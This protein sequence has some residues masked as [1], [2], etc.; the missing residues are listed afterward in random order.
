[1]SDSN[2]YELYIYISIIMF[3][4]FSLLTSMF[5]AFDLF[6]L[7]KDV[8]I[9]EQSIGKSLHADKREGITCKSLDSDMRFK[10]ISNEYLL[11]EK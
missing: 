10:V 1:M 5:I 2:K 8:R 7:K 4:I 11:K 3:M 6:C 9:I